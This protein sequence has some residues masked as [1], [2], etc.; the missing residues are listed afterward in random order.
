MTRW[1]NRWDGKS[2]A[3]RF[4]EKV[5]K[6]DGCWTWLAA[7]DQNGYGTFGRR[8]KAHRVA[9]ALTGGTVP[10]GHELDHL[11]RNRACVRPDHLEPVTHAENM[12]RGA[13][14]RPPATH[15]RRGHSLS[16]HNEVRR[17]NGHRQC[18]VCLY[19]RNRENSRRYRAN[20]RALNPPPP[21]VRDAQGRFVKGNNVVWLGERA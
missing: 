5:A 11:C 10:D 13:A 15:C 6:S 1:G 8:E 18:R 16:G 9:F 14:A 17:P 4:W 20:A 19:E 3:E 21:R 2:R 12:R 7:T